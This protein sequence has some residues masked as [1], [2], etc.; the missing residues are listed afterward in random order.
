[1]LSTY[2]SACVAIV[3]RTTVPPYLC[4]AMDV[5][6]VPSTENV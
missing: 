5:K 6:G 1:M 3:G 4:K 2:Q